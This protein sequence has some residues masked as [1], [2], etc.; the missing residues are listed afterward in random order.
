MDALHWISGLLV[1]AL[2]YLGSC[3]LTALSRGARLPA[4]VRIIPNLF[5]AQAN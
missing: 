3:K 2:E 5:A 4:T 1:Q